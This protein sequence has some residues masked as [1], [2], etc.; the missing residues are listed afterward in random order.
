MDAVIRYC[1]DEDF[2]AVWEIINDGA[3]AYK[4]LI[5]SDRW[6]EPYMSEEELRHEID[7]GVRFW[8]FE[9]SGSLVAVMGMQEVLDVTLI[10]HAYVRSDRQGKGIGARMLASLLEMARS[11]VL[12]G[13]WAASTRAIQFYERNG[14]R[15][16]SAREKDSLLRRYWNV[17][18]RQIETSVVLAHEGL[19]PN[20]GEQQ[21]TAGDVKT[22][23]GLEPHPRE[24]GW[25]RRTYA[26][27]VMLS[28]SVFSGCSEPG[29]YDGPRR[30][31]SAIYYL[32]EPG[33]F[34]EMHRLGS[35]EVFHHYAGAAVEMLQLW[36]GGR[37]ERV[38]IGKDLL[39]GQR[40]Q[41]VVPKG[42]WQGSRVLPPQ[43]AGLPG[44]PLPEEAQDGAWALMGC[45]VS[46]GF[47]YADYE[48][49]TRG[50]LVR[51][52]PEARELIFALTRSGVH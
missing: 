43:G 15:L 26:S 45:T 16:V 47:E 40:P 3:R 36:P 29:R 28:A 8:G 37:T 25:Y 19:A 17:P 23:L 2:E 41:V 12:V 39:A 51:S 31:H 18:E 20:G 4:G 1:K 34:S 46:P 35:D 6:T 7:V 5:P 52:Y 24:G 49:G 14:F 27:G 32:L 11:P 42:V 21:M 33:N 30:L 9:D 48:T 38:V 44:T 10:R 22:L 50:E 13:T